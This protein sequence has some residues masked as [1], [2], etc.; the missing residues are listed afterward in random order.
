MPLSQTGGFDLERYKKSRTD[1][2]AKVGTINR[3][4]VALPHLFTK[5]VKW[6]ISASRHVSRRLH[7]NT[8]ERYPWLFISP[9]QRDWNTVAIRKPFHRVVEVAGMGR[10]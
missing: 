7:G 2:D 4:L 10:G 8:S 6:G 3:E 1:V 9:T 5:A